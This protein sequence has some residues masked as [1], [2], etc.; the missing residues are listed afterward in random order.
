MQLFIKPLV[1]GTAAA[2]LFFIGTGM[3]LA[4]GKGNKGG[5]AG[6]G[7]KASQGQQSQ[8]KKVGMGQHNNGMV[9]S[10]GQSQF[11]H[12]QIFKKDFHW[13]GTFCYNKG[14]CWNYPWYKSYCSYPVYNYFYTCPILFAY[15]PQVITTQVIE[16]V[17]PVPV[18]ETVTTTTTSTTGALFRSGIQQAPVPPQ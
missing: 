10:N 1:T 9:K 11:Q 7:V 8:A 18:V 13:N 15:R 6:S 12:Q 16:V 5:L 2:V 14:S 3:A 17:Q 4:D